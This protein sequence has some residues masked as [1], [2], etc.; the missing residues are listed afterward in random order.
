M[1]FKYNPPTRTFCSVCEKIAIDAIKPIIDTHSG[2]ASS[3]NNFPFHNWYNFVLGYSPEFPEYI[4][5][6]ENISSNSIVLD[7]F[8]GTGTTN[9]VCKTNNIN[10]FGLEANDYF[11]N[12]AKTKLNWD[13]ELN[14][15]VSLSEKLINEI[16][17]KLDNISFKEEEDDDEATLFDDSQYINSVILEKKSYKKI[18]ENRPVEL[19]HKYICDKPFV[20]IQT[21]IESI[22]EIIPKKKKEELSFFNLALSSIIV[23]CSN[24]SYGPGFGVKKPKNDIDVFNIFKLKINKM[25]YDLQKSK[26]KS[27]LKTKHEIILGDSRSISKHIAKNS[28]DF[29]I[30]S[31]PY[32]GDHEYTKHTKLELIFENHA[33]TIKEFRVIKKRMLT[34]STT[35]IYKEDNDRLHVEGNELITKVTD[36]IQQ[37]LEDD[38][39]TSGFEKLYTRLVWEYFGGMALVFKESLKILKKGGKFSLLVSDS[40]AFKMVHIQTAVI[41]KDIALKEGYSLGEIELWQNKKSTSHGYNLREEIL[42]ITK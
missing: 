39:A 1:A 17:A 38:N 25:I 8:M 7:P 29:M 32:P 28:I 18:A 9:V 22:Y 19:L 30:T 11:I 5:K 37:R 13:F 3:A 16:S 41:L 14:E 26:E 15:I 6:K 35:N 24:I 27:L 31:P 36:L 20:K 21:I 10:S 40:H 23:P 12:V 42:T 33:K 4:I 2:K 34:G